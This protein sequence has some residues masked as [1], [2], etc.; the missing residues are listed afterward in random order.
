[1]S[2]FTLL[3]KN[4]LTW[5]RH[6]LL[7]S[8]GI[9]VAIGLILWGF[10]PVSFAAT[11]TGMQNCGDLY[12][13]LGPRPQSAGSNSKAVQA[14]QCFVQ[15]HQQCKAASLSYTVHGVDTGDTEIYYTAN[16]LGGCRLSGTSSG[17]VDVM[18]RPTTNFGC[19]GIVQ[20]SDGLHFLSCGNNGEMVVPNTA[21]M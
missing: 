5:I 19:S 12:S 4:V 7:L 8:V 3:C 6:H 9:V 2:P 18:S 15:A 20:Q 11:Y 14:I 16:G 13:A 17:F 21:V 10:G 1:M